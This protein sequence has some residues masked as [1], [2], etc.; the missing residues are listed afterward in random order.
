MSIPVPWPAWV[1]VC[2]VRS[3]LPYSAR[4]RLVRIQECSCAGVFNGF[5]ITYRDQTR[6]T[7]LPSAFQI[8][9]D[10]TTLPTPGH[11]FHMAL[12]LVPIQDVERLVVP[13]FRPQHRTTTR[14]TTTVRLRLVE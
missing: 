14:R 10:S 6:G 4:R 5:F 1:L 9:S 7:L 3:T 11:G 13:I 12:L 2:T 8:F